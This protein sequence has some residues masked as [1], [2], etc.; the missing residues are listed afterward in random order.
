MHTYARGIGDFGIE[1]FAFFA[2]ARINHVSVADVR[3]DVVNTT[4]SLKISAR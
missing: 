3:A 1:N 4:H 2:N